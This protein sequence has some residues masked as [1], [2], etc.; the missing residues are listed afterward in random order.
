MVIVIHAVPERLWYVEEHLIPALEAQ[1]AENIRIWND[2]EHRGN[3]RA[4]MECFAAM[5]GDGGA[6]HLQDDVLPAADFVQRCS[7]LDGGVVWG[8]CC[9]YFLDDPGQVGF[10][11]PEDAWHSFQCVRIPD[12]YARACAE[13]FFSGRWQELQDP[14]LELQYEDNRGDDAFFRRWLQEAHPA[15]AVYN[16]RPCL[17]EHVDLW[18]GGSVISRN[19]WRD[20]PARAHWFDGDLTAQLRRQL[21]AA[22]R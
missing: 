13:W 5:D 9:E 4:C 14:E 6:W 3:L 16:T 11:Y 19:Q 21:R 8:F 15:E 17:V 20:Y 12:S 1:G 22:K 2:L 10:V 7:L 18:I